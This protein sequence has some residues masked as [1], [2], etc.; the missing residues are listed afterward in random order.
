MTVT[1]VT[2][3]ASHEVDWHAIEW[4][5]V[6]RNVRR[7]QAR[8]V[9]ATQEGR[10]GKVKSLQRLLTHSFSGKALAVRRV[11]ENQ[12]KRTPGVDNEIWEHL[13][14]KQKQ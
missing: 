9:K 6:Y 4:Q 12:G 13:Q 1:K 2:G 10:W 7:L 11:T 3:A 5:K 8:I 14:R